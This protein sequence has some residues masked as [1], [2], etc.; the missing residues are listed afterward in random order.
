MTPVTLTFRDG[1][2]AILGP[3]GCG[4]TNV[5]DAVRWV[6]GEQS[7]RQLRGA[8]MENVIFNGTEI[9]KPMG[10]AV[11]NLTIDNERGLFPLD[12]SE[13]T[14]TRKVY[15]SGISEYFINKSPC[16][17]KDVKELFADTG[18]GSHSYSVIEQE[19]I[20]Y[21]LNDAHGERRYMFEEASGIVKYRM[22]CEEAQRKLKL[23]EA[24]LVRLE[25]I[26]EEL[27]KQ[28]RSLRYQMGK[29][30]RYKTIQER[31]RQWELVQLRKQ[32]SAQLEGRRVAES[33]LAE[34]IELSSEESVSLGEMSKRVEEEKFRLVELEKRN[35][36]LQ[37]LRYEV[38]K[39]IQ[40]SEER[41]IQYTERQRQA[42]Q[43]IERAGREIEE[44]QKRLESIVGKTVAAA[45]ECA[46][47][48]AQIISKQES[49][50]SATGEFHDINERLEKLKERLLVCKQT[51]LDFL[52]DQARVKS[53]LEHYESILS[54]LDSRSSEIRE[55]ILGLEGEAGRY[56]IEKNELRAEMDGM[57][58]D[59]RNKE[60]E[61]EQ[62]NAS[63]TEIEEGL[64]EREHSLTGNKTEH[65]RLKSR[66]ELCVRMKEDFEGYPGGARYILK[67]G[68][69]RVRGPLAE[70][71]T[72]EDKFRPSL[73][74]VLGGL[75]DGIVVE[76][77][78]D[79]VELVTEL[80]NRDLGKV[81]LFTED[82]GSNHRTDAPDESLGYLGMLNSLVTVD[83]SQKTLVESLLGDVCVFDTTENALNFVGSEDGARC[84]AVTLSGIYFCRGRGIYFSGASGDEVSLLARSEEI[85]KMEEAIS[86]L[87]EGASDL[88]GAC[89]ADRERRE[90]HRS[91]VTELDSEI[92]GIREELATKREAYAAAE[93]NHVTSKEKRSLLLKSLEEIE[94]SRTDILS[95]LEEM[96]LSLEIRV[97]GDEVS[98]GAELERELASV[99]QRRDQLDAELT[100]RKVELASL[101]G[102][103]EKK[104]EEIR[105]LEEMKK[106][107]ESLIELRK[108]E[109]E[110]S[111]EEM[112]ALHGDIEHE[113][114]IVHEFVEHEKSYQSGIDELVGSLEE[115]RAEINRMEKEFK[116]KQEEREQIVSRENKLRVTLSS[117]ET[118]MK[119]LVDRADEVH[120]ADLHCYLAGEE[121]PMGEGEEGITPEMLEQEKRKLESIGAVNLAAVEEYEE[122]KARLDFLSGQKDD[123]ISACDELG[124]A[125]RK[126]NTRAR[127]RFVEIFD[128]VSE[129]FAETFRVLFEGGEAS[130]SLSAGTDPLEADIIISARPKGKRLQDISLL[131]GGERA[132][133]ALALLF[134][135]YK[136]KPSPFCILDEVDAPLDDANIQ[137]FV[138]M[139]KRF[140]EDTQF[141]IITHNK[142]TMEVADMLYGVTMEEKGISNLVSVDLMDIERVLESSRPASKAL[143]ESPVSTN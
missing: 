139:L 56:K 37:N 34:V 61:R 58:S 44:A 51:Q 29:A 101:K 87:Q 68:D 137:R 36:E 136:A 45:A 97:Q 121:V 98:E 35:T 30:T 79:A 80:A 70:L 119:D 63:I 25:D 14:I 81:R 109:I 49:I 41:V 90:T 42:E 15:R 9:Y 141:I 65:A 46:D 26:M 127:K 39:K 23:T 82:A 112:E 1:I 54:Q 59:L 105:G 140:Q 28:V 52:Q 4:K 75:L 107:F 22:R 21:V 131:S 38:R 110:S 125:I 130:L 67:K 7:A 17:L 122:K 111:G 77:F 24:D 62:V 134:A 99:Q 57:R 33:S 69:R 73:E 135:L 53:S 96:R 83:K 43:R 47:I 104:N 78:V 20:E 19:M 115:K 88:A 27:G 142:K 124:E 11:V 85:T 64:A 12:Y 129:Y 117:I 84:N 92:A 48:E 106:Q 102:A 138:R 74:A 2:T 94:G 143:V 123:L 114:G 91:R 13:I 95:K 118:R 72:V 60:H 126:I 116:S 31:I 128:L 113:R 93:T 133:T 66:H 76:S 89:E 55:R 71:L 16:R 8:K 103:L 132:L 40:T 6:L 108:T 5:V 3:N 18:S 100:E 86:R 10:Y 120:G 32:L 50:N